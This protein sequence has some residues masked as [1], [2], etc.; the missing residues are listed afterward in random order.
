LD[1]HNWAWDSTPFCNKNI[2]F[3]YGHVSLDQVACCLIP[4]YQEFTH[5]DWIG[6]Y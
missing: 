1:Q 6:T 3:A 2:D 4:I 5:F